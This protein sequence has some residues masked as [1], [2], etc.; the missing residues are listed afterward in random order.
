MLFRSRGPGSP[1]RRGDRPGGS[2][3]HDV[4][5]RALSL[6]ILALAAL[7]LPAAVP[8]QDESAE[9]VAEYDIEVATVGGGTVLL[10]RTEATE[11]EGVWGLQA[12]GGYGQVTSVVDVRTDVVERA[13]RTVDGAFREGDRAR[14]SGYFEASLNY[15]DGRDARKQ[16]QILGRH[17]SFNNAMRRGNNEQ[18]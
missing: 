13:F 12:A 5:M 4:T 10:T 8:L 7:L 14:L 9:L 1:C 6:P 2:H 3:Y 16:R 18:R 11:T 17:R 15:W